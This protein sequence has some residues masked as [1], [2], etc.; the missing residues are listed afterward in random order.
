VGVLLY[1]PNAS[2]STLGWLLAVSGDIMKAWVTLIFIASAVGL[3]LF[4]MLVG[5]DAVGP[6]LPG[7]QVHSPGGGNHPADPAPL[8]ATSGVQPTVLPPQS[9]ATTPLQR[10]IPPVRV[11][12]QLGPVSLAVQL[13]ILPG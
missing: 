9:A 5:P 6:L 7:M 2:E 8:T 11:L 10:P 1:A 4:G 3:L 12:S 13:A